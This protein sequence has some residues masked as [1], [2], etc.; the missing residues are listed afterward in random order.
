MSQPAPE[1]QIIVTLLAVVNELQ[2]QVTVLSEQIAKLEVENKELS[3]R[4]NT[5]SR[6]SSKPPSTD[7]YTKP[8]AKKTSCSTSENDSKDDKP[9]PKSLRQKSGLKPG[10]QKGHK[11]TTLQQ[12]EKT[13]RTRYHPVIDCE[14]CHRS[15]RAEKPIKL[16]ERQV[17]EPGRFG[18]F[19]VT[20]HVAEV[21]K[22]S[23]G[24]VTQGS[25]PEGVDAHVQYGPVTQA[26]AVYLCQYQ[27]VPY[28][29]TSQFFMDI[30]GLEVSP[31]SICTFQKNAYD[32]LAS[33]EQ[34]ITDALKGEA[35]AGADETGMRVAGTLWWMRGCMSC[36]LR[37]GRF[38]TL[39]PVK[40]TLP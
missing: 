24:H 16:V 22:C 7:G 29:R 21:K 1:F 3:A 27:L 31:G 5:N 20:A 28:K 34:A 15:L 2:E 18:H 6:N 30:F 37:N 39:I 23:C 32:Q 33:T 40:A 38:T 17:F 4:L 35:I 36:V 13:E 8:P 10:G 11:G 25:F 12:A 26:L 9:N 19:E 14:K